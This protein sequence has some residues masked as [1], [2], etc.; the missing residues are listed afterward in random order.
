MSHEG[1]LKKRQTCD[2]ELEGRIPLTLTLTFSPAKGI[3][4]PLVFDQMKCCQSEAEKEGIVDAHLLN[5]ML[6]VYTNTG[7]I[8]PALR[9]YDAE[10]KKHGV[11]SLRI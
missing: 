9:F 4:H 2:G 8:E 1:E 6:Q 10:Y 3:Q 11:V 5:G 7:Q